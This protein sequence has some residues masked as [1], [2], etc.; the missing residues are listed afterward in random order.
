[1]TYLIA[2]A[3]A[4]LVGVLVY[5][6]L[7]R[8]FGQPS[9]SGR[10]AQYTGEQTAAAAEPRPRPQSAGL[11]GVGASV[12][13]LAPKGI[14]AHYDRQLQAASVPIK[15]EEMA[16]AAAGCFALGALLGW[17]L[18]QLPGALIGAVVGSQLPELL[19]KSHQKKRLKNADDQLVDFL[20]MTAN[21]LRAGYSFQQALDLASREMP[22]PIGAELRRTL[23]EVNLGVPLDTALQR[24][25]ERLPTADLDLL[26]TAVLVQRQVGG[27]LAGIMDK[28]AFTIRERQRIKGKIMSQT[29]QGRMSGIII[30]VLPLALLAILNVVSPDYMSTMFRHPLGIT[31]LAIG[32]V[33]IFLGII[34]IKKIVNI[35]I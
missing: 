27:D 17:L 30:S 31:L 20:A 23:R 34:M 10:M 13:R 25:V 35:D 21:A 29:A 24:L 33:M 26:V 6:L 1:M 2:V 32:A 5:L 28:M 15:G 9:L 12:G 4:A 16:G 11:R 14:V 22:D 19:L 8:A 3:V 18:L 7:Q